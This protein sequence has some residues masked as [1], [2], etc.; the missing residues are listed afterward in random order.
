MA[1]LIVL[2]LIAIAAVYGL[3]FV[4]FKL[5]ALL[6]KNKSNKG[7]FIWAGVATGIVVVLAGVAMYRLYQRVLEPFQPIVQTIHAQSNPIYGQR[8][9]IDPQYGFSITTYNGM[10]FSRWIKLPDDT[11]GLA[12]IDTN[13]FLKQTPA[14]E[15]TFTGMFI[16]RKAVP[17]ATQPSQL[18]E[19]ILPQLTGMSSAKAQLQL[20]Q[21]PE[22]ITLGQDHPA[23]F[24]TGILYAPELPEGNI[25]LALLITVHQDIAYYVVG[26]STQADNTL[27]NSLQSLR[28]ES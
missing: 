6:R 28:F 7:P 5:I 26:I 24:L 19:Q 16:L 27:W 8:L 23:S 20:T 12:G 15:K 4:I 2:A 22:L 21:E 11:E 17:V 10:V 13:T 25:Q 1:E 18:M 9:Y 3:F 14:E